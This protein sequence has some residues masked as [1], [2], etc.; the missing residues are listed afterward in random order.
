MKR[1]ILIV[2]S[3]ITVFSLSSCGKE[4]SAQE[5][6][7]EA[8]SKAN[9]I[10]STTKKDMSK[11]ENIT[12]AQK[13]FFDSIGKSEKGKKYVAYLDVENYLVQYYCEYSGQKINKVTCYRYIKNQD[14]FNGIKLASESSKTV[15]VN[16]EAMCV[17]IDMTESYKDKTFDELKNELT[18]YTAVK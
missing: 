13:K 14:I 1:I 4:K 18:K 8:V 11:I 12:D 7:N 9:E 10:V 16:D 17:I 5:R 3:I 15:T 6:A 2:L